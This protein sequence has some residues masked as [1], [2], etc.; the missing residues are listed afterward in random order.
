[1]FTVYQIDNSKFSDPGKQNSLNNIGTSK[2]RFP[3]STLRP[4]LQAGPSKE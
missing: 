2:A 1:M 3:D 4:T